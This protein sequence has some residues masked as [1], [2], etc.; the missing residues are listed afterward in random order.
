[1][2]KATVIALILVGVIALGGGTIYA[3]GQIAKSNAITEETALNFAYVDAGVLPENA[4]VVS[5]EF[6]WE[7]GKFVYEIEFISE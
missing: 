2:K 1:M 5:V 7:K 4:E 3:V 6:E